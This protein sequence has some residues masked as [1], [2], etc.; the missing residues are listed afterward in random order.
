MKTKLL[1]AI[2]LSIP[3]SVQAQADER[4]NDWENPAVLGINKLPYHAT[5]QLPSKQKACQEIVSLDGQWLF[6]WSKDPESRPADFYKEDYDV[7]GWDKI[8]VPGN[9]QL[10]GYGKPIYVN[11]QYP[12]HRDRPKVTGEPNKD[13]YAYDHR[14]PV[15]SYVTFV[16]VTKEMQGKNLI[17]HFGGVHS[18]MYVW[19]NGQKVGYSQNSMSPAE[20]DVTKFLHEGRN[21]LAVEVYRWSDGSYLECQDMWRLSGIFR[22][23]QLWVRPLVHIAD[24]KVEAIPNADFSKAEVTADIAICNTGKDKVKYSRVAFNI[25]GKTIE[26]QL[27]SL[28]SGDTTHVRLTYQIDNPKLWSA[29][30]PNLYSYSIELG[31]EHFENHFG[32]RRVECV[33]EV[34]KINGKKVKLRGVNRH[35][36]HPV[37]GRYVD[38]A[39][40]EQDIR[41]MKQANIN[42]LRTSHYPDREYLYELCDRWG[43]YVMDEANQESHGYGY[44]NH[45]MGEDPE[46]REAHVDRAVSL[47]ERDKNHPSVIMW[48]LGNEGGVGPNLKAMREAVVALDNTRIPFCDTDHSQSDIYDD[49]YLTPDKLREEARRI[50]DRPFMM[51]EYAH[52]MGNSMGNFQ[53]YWD[54]IY[55]DSSICGAAIWDWVDQGIT[56]QIAKQMDNGKWKIDNEAARQNGNNYQLSII[57]YPFL[58]GGDFGDKPN[59]GPFCINGLVDPD[60][61]PHPHYYEVQYVYQPIAFRFV[62][63]DSTVR[64]INRDYFT[65]INEYE[66]YVEV[67]HQGELV[68]GELARIKDNS[69]F[70]VP[71]PYFP[72]ND[73]ELTLN[74]YARLRKATPWAPEGFVVAREQF[75]LKAYEFPTPITP[76]V[77]SK[78]IT[79]EG[80]ALTSWI[81]DGQEMLQAP[82]E[83]YFW[84]PENDNQHAAGFARR[85]AVWREASDVTVN[86]TV[87]NDKCIQVDVDYHPTGTDKPIMPKFGMRMRIPSDFTNIEYYGRGPWENYPDRK[88]SAFI[89]RYQM[90]LS[91]YETE[92]IHPQDNG[93]RCDVRWF[94][95]GNKQQTLRIKALEPL[96]IRAWDYGEEDLEGLR[97]GG[98]AV[99]PAHPHEINRGRFVN[100]NIDQNIHGVGGIDTW[101]QRT[102]PQYTIDG[103]KP[104]HYGFILEWQ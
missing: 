81:V 79:I 5:L 23:V 35:D 19:V 24:Y 75:V 104:H 69:W 18:A 96:C 71:Y 90:P 8:T 31:N 87:I 27:K 91:E 92:Y 15:G 76:K 28:A 42:F 10:Q 86:Y 84:K 83:P 52:A 17:L 22:S 103:N 66:Y 56:S 93:N 98:P 44:A 78:N 47:V 36:H 14:N 3:F 88:Q 4:R 95:I 60:R 94:N 30:K 97:D 40:Y 7:S 12:F 54:V 65:D 2:L 55:A 46:W 26:G 67:Y 59:D 13:W 85:T 33:G 80:N 102:L 89:G 63:A 53:E 37:T 9:W 77:S 6:H 20:F 32:V 11:M 39:T 43:I 58:Y 34:F 82:L 41:L 72:Y 64:I 1:I 50:S 51:R 21:K 73:P 49:G 48:S 29:E 100:L 99:P 101:G 38:D 25:D 68:I 45:E 61:K 70:K 62:E 74:V 16:D 57:N